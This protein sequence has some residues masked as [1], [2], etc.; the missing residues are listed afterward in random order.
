[1]SRI[2]F[3]VGILYWTWP[4]AI[5]S[6]Q[7][8]QSAS[9]QS[10][11]N[12]SDQS[13]LALVTWDGRRLLIKW[14]GSAEA[15]G[16]ADTPRSKFNFSKQ[17]TVR[18][19][20]ADAKDPPPILGKVERTKKQ[21]H[22]VF[23]PRFAF[24][25]G[26]KLRIELSDPTEHPQ[27]VS[28]RFQVPL[29]DQKETK[30]VAVYP[31]ANELPANLL[32]FYIHFSSPMQRGNIYQ[33]FSVVNMQTRK[34]VELPFLELQEELWSRDGKRLTLFFDPGRIKRGLKPRADMGAIFEVGNSYQFRISK[35][36]LNRNGDPLAANYVKT[37]RVTTDDYQ[38]PQP[39]KWKLNIPESGTLNPLEI[40]FDE[41]LD[42]A[43]AKRAIRLF[44]GKEELMPKQLDLMQLEK[45]L[46]M[47]P[48]SR[49]GSGS[50][51]IRIGSELEDLCG[52]RVEKAF[53]VDLKSR[54][55]Q[56]TESVQKQG[57][58]RVL[59]FQVR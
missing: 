39:A 14:N 28:L 29:G 25:P 4:N 56:A 44:R 43:L 18:V 9:N 36:W 11:S 41:S 45:K 34:E 53:D 21:P 51:Q 37:F 30:V 15:K 5:S 50:Y 31:S 32:K 22:L 49:W 19:F 3:L 16:K 1:M 13:D 48:A 12:Q 23:S 24:L 47:T 55:S 52:N 7:E 6:A 33:Y 35:S 54:Q 8:N 27:K 26:T 42:S 17:T 58:K 57:N 20:L 10:A 40:R 59:T 2:L 46:V 38:T